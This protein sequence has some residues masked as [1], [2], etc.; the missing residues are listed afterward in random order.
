MSS[1]FW[2]RI[3]TGPIAL[4]HNGNLTNTER[5]YRELE[6]EG[7]I[8]QTSMDSEIVIHLLARRKSSDMKEWFCRVLAELE[9]RLFH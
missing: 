1:R 6:E 9:G 7:A 4:A 8:F 5:L 3:R 2:R